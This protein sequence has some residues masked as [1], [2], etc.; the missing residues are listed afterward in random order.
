M[1]STNIWGDLCMGGPSSC[2]HCGKHGGAALL[3]CSACKQTRY[4]GAECQ[5]AAWK[6]HKKTCAFRLPLDDVRRKLVA[7]S[8]TSE[9]RE[10]LKWEC[11]LTELMEDAGE[12]PHRDVIL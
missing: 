7:L 12:N 2:S 11:R 6:L 3:R 5:K 9:W 8:G 1:A 4:C 10:V